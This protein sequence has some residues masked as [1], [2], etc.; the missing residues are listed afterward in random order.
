[1]SLEQR[2]ETFDCLTSRFSCERH[3]PLVAAHRINPE[4]FMEFQL[5]VATY[6][7]HSMHSPSIPFVLE[8][9][10]LRTVTER[11]NKE[12]KNC[13][14]N[15]AIIPKKHLTL[16]F[17]AVY[18]AYVDILASLKIGDLLD[19]LGILMNIRFKESKVHEANIGRKFATEYAHSDAWVGESTHGVNIFIPIF[20]DISRNRLDFFVPD[21]SFSEL[22]LGPTSFADGQKYLENYKKIH[23]P[24]ERGFVYFFDYAVLHQTVRESNCGPRISMDN[25]LFPKLPPEQSAGEIGR[26]KLLYEDV[27]AIGREKLLVFHHSENESVDTMNASRHAAEWHLAHLQS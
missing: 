7:S 19:S 10:L 15:G 26:P 22:W 14:P 20:G 12:M 4:L 3:G 21:N 17:N 8:G 18:R 24:I 13:T 9:L 23:V 1:M 6:V 27:Q 16:E 5:A 11:R 2:V 25:T